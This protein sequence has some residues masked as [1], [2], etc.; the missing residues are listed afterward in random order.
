VEVEMLAEALKIW[1]ALHRVHERWRQLCWQPMG[2]MTISQMD[3]LWHLCA[4]KCL[5]DTMILGE[6]TQ[7]SLRL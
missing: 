6:L 5:A 4:P 7:A 3:L 1:L 2:T